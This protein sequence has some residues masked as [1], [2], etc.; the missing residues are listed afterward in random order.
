MLTRFFDKDFSNL[1]RRKTF[2][3]FESGASVV[4]Q[5]ISLVKRLSYVLFL[6]YHIAI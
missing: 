5:P 4:S 6:N 2:S 1:G 3:L